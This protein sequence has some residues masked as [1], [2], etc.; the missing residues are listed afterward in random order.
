MKD[1]LVSAHAQ[2]KE[3]CSYVVQVNIRVT[4]TVKGFEDS[5]TYF[6]F[7]HVFKL[8]LLRD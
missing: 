8:C 7:I 1:A 2:K 4:Y 3:L 5:A 6:S